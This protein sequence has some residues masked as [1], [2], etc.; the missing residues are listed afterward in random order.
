M[1]SDPS[2][3]IPMMTNSVALDPPATARL[4]PRNQLTI[5]AQVA[6]R[7]RAKPGDGF[8]IL[9]DSPDSIRMVRIRGSYAGALPGLWGSTQAEADEWLRSE[10]ASWRRRQERYHPED[11]VGTS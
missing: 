1:G 4:R 10:R 11:P 6:A 3:V 5:P 9:V 2:A 8:L 7:L